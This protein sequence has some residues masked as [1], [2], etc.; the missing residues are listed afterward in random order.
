MR[1]I[2]GH[3]PFVVVNLDDIP[4]FSKTVKE[5]MQQALQLLKDDKLY[6]KLSRCE[7]FNEKAKFSSHLVGPE[8]LHTNPD[9]VASV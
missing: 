4:M 5:H 6:A 8:G 3:L 7:L 9:K 2:F 1:G